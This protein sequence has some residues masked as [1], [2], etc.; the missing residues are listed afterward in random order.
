MNSTP[1]MRYIN[2]LRAHGRRDRFEQNWI[3]GLKMPFERFEA[4]DRRDVESGCSVL[5]YD[6][7]RAKARCG[8]GLTSGEIAC[9]ASHS[10]V[11]REELDRIGTAGVVICEDD[12]VPLAGASNLTYHL[13]AAIKSLPGT[14]VILFTTPNGKCK[15][16]EIVNGAMRVSK[17]PWG[18]VGIWYSAEGLSKAHKLISELDAP[19]DWILPDFASRGELA[20]L[21][22]P[23]AGHEGAD[24]FIGCDFGRPQR[25]YIE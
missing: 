8:R 3:T 22:P 23:V 20:I 24:T 5:P 18:T 19:A 2:L 1:R 16:S 25:T 11:M 6:E 7:A 9:S 12:C 15:Y 4:I 13:E 21:T 14:H 10:L 17:A